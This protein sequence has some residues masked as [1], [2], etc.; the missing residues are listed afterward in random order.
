MI[1]GLTPIE[2]LAIADR[3]RKRAERLEFHAGH[4]LGLEGTTSSPLN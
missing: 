3:Q 4:Q 2:I 1:Q